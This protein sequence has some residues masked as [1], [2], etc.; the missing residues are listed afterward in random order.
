MPWD[1]CYEL[2]FGAHAAGYG[3]IE[4]NYIQSSYKYIYLDRSTRVIDAPG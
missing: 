2:G 4:D 1:V 3:W